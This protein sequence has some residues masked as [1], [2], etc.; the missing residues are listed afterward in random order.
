MNPDILNPPA[1]YGLPLFNAVL[2]HRAQDFRVDEVLELDFSGSG[3]HL[4]LQLEKT[5][6][7][8]DELTSLLEQAYSVTSADIGYCGL[9]DRHSVS[10]QWFSIRTPDT[11]SVFEQL[12][13]T[14]NEQQR[15]QWGGSSGYLKGIRLVRSERHSR[16][17]KRGAHK[18]NR[19]VIV[20]RDV[21]PC[22]AGGEGG[23]RTSDE[24]TLLS[25]AVARRIELIIS[26]GFPAYIGAQRFGHGGQNL[27]RA[28]QWF[29]KSGK[30]TSRQ[31]RSL[32]LS[33]ARSAMFNVVCAA[34]VRDGSWL[35]LMEGEPAMLDGTGSFFIARCADASAVTEGAATE[36]AAN[37][38]NGVSP[39]TEDAVAE[40]ND[41]VTAISAGFTA[42]HVANLKQRLSSHDIHPSAPWWGRGRATA[43]GACADYEAGVLSPFA[44]LCA[45]LERAGLPQERRALRGIAQALCVEWQSDTVVELRFSLAPGIFATTLLRELGSCTEPARDA[46]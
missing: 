27:Q 19:F 24:Q 16:K 39:R 23:A 34:R 5:S 42:S 1:A 9:K 29:K 30:R 15:L 38:G 44:D 18:G 37:E 32:W 3:E 4:Y 21:Q 43:Q 8:T 26:Q 11:I 12:A 2:K 46:G 33:A 14:F 25:E 20:L 17:L 22:G 10:T 45:G 31:Q 35:G 13:T 41:A 28:R 6:M 40:T 36:G 7:N